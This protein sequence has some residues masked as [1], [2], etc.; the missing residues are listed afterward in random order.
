MSKFQGFTPETNRFFR[1]LE[2][3]ND[4]D[5]FDGHREDYLKYVRQPMEQLAAEL[6]PMVRE[7]DPML[8]PEPNRHI[9]RIYRDTRFSKDKTPY[10]PCRWMAFRRNL[11][12]WYQMPTY[13]FEV[14]KDGYVFGMNVYSPSAATMRRFREMID[15]QPDD[16][17]EMIVPI[18]RSRSIV[19]ES[20]RYKKPFKHD[21]AKCIDPWYQSRTI[22]LFCRRKPDKILFSPHLADML[23]ER[24]I[25]IK[26]LYDFLWKAVVP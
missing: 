19:L 9:S 16:F 10:W 8:V 20:D 26:P 7:L 17:R 13:L 18:A 24:F 25:M 2:K 3:N 21:H 15:E 11:K 12:N 1:D 14:D 5:W 4:R 23:I 22:A 6:L